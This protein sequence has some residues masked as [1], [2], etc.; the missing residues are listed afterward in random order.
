MPELD[1]AFLNRV[2]HDLRGELA[3]MVAGVHYLMRYEA[4]V[5]APGRQMLERV[6]RAGQRLRRLLDELELSGWIGGERGASPVQERV[7][8]GGLV[9]AAVLRLGPSITQRGVQVNLALSED[10][11]E[12]EVDPDL[13][14]AVVEL[15]IDFAVARAPG[16]SVDV[17]A[18][19]EGGGVA[20]TVRDHGGPLD[21]ALLARAFEPFFE[22]ELLPKPEP[23]GR[24]RERLGLGLAIAHGVA[25][26]HQGSLEAAPHDDGLALTLR[27]A[28]PG[29]PRTGAV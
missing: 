23:G 29:C 18:A 14:G 12:I 2:A 17:G 6:E 7:S 19:A 4:G 26:A 5:S 10:L 9:Q 25:R 20:L 16:A 3:T 28:A 1:D 15:V 24:R 21:A 11:P 13:L 8:L 27:I 22:K